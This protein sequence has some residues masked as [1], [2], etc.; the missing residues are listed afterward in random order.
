MVY[1]GKPSGSSFIVRVWVN[2][3]SIGLL[4]RSYYQE[5]WQWPVGAKQGRPKVVLARCD[6][7]AVVTIVE[8]EAM[9]LRICLVFL[10]AKWDG[11]LYCGQNMLDKL[12][13]QIIRWWMHYLET[14]LT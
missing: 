13:K 5:S 10:E 12:E 4:S 2:Q 6:N 14:E 8:A 7:M 9:H 11:V 3:P 1:G